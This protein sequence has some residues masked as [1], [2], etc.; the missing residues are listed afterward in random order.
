MNTTLPIQAEVDSFLRDFFPANRTNSFYVTRLMEQVI[1][2][3]GVSG[4]DASLKYERSHGLTSAETTRIEQLTHWGCI[5][6]LLSN[7]IKRTG[8]NE[9]QHIT[10]SR[11]VYSSGRISRKMVGEAMV[12]VRILWG[13]NKSPEEILCE[14]SG[15]CGWTDDAIEVAIQRVAAGE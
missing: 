14:L 1:S 15:V 8:P 7:D 9:Y 4:T 10:G 6:L 2:H 3:F 12:S 13:L 11:P 5:H